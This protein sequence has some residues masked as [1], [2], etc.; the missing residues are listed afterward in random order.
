LLDNAVKFT[1]N[2]GEITIETTRLKN[3]VAVTITDNGRGMTAE[4]QKYIF[5]RFYKGDP[6]RGEDKMGS[7]LGLSIVRA[8]VRAHGENISVESVAGGGSVFSFTIPV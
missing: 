1:Q 8:F 6:S 7:G 5:D 4:E 3:K 2:G